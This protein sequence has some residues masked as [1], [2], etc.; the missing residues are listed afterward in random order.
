MPQGKRSIRSS[1]RRI[2]SKDTV[3]RACLI[4]PPRAAAAVL[5]LDHLPSE[6]AYFRYAR[7]GAYVL[8]FKAQPRT[9]PFGSRAKPEQVGTGHKRRKPSAPARRFSRLVTTA[10]YPVLVY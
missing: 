2:N 1:R 8:A 5:A 3:D 4:C 10:P 9:L 7:S 6:A